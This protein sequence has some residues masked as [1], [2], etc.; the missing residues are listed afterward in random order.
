MRKG[1]D[2][3]SYARQ[4]TKTWKVEEHRKGSRGE[5]MGGETRGGSRTQGE[6]GEAKIKTSN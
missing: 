4:L 1:P 6:G 2:K 3:G 5:E